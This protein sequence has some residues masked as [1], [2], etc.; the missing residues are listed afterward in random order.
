MAATFNKATVVA[1]EEGLGLFGSPYSPRFVG[2]WP[3]AAHSLLSWGSKGRSL[4]ARSIPR[5]VQWVSNRG[6]ALNVERTDENGRAIA[7]DMR[8]GFED[9]ARKLVNVN[10]DGTQ[11]DRAC[12]YSTSLP[13]LALIQEWRSQKHRPRESITL[14]THLSLD[15]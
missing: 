5:Y 2:T 15:R 14:M 13:K 1:T 11:P 4:I 12:N 3:A 9:P 8:R 10:V 6:P 7:S